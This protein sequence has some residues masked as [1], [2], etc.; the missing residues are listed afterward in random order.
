MHCRLFRVITVLGALGSESAETM[1]VAVA[2]TEAD[3][4]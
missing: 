3:L 4:L 2:L 1:S